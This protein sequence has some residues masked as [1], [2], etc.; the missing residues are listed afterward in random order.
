MTNPPLV[1]CLRWLVCLVILASIIAGLYISGSP[2]T[3]RRYALDEQR[4]SSL[5]QLTFALDQYK[6]THGNLPPT[7]DLLAGDQPHISYYARDLES[8][9]PYEYRV[10]TTSTY[11]LCATFDLPTAKDSGSQLPPAVIAPNGL[12]GT[13]WEHDA[14]RNCFLLDVR[15]PTL[16][17][18]KVSDVQI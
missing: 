2:S 10:M 6:Q 18:Q 11:E 8:Q 14:G 3:R 13:N 7:L 12:T 17:P 15:T 1:R 4:L 16:A 9:I 5:S